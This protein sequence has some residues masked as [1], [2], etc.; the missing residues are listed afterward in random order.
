MAPQE[1]KHSILN[2]NAVNFGAHAEDATGLSYYLKGMSGAFNAFY[3]TLPVHEKIREYAGA[4]SRDIRFFPL[5]LSEKE[6]AKLMD[7]L[8]TWQEKPFPYKFFTYNC[9]HGI[10]ALLAASLDSLP[11][12]PNIMS[13]QDLALMLQNAN[14][15]GKPYVLPSLKERVLN[16]NNKEVAKLEFLE[17]KNMQKDAKRDTSRQRELAEL[18]HSVSK[19]EKEKR[20]LLKLENQKLKVHGYS[21]FDIGTQFIEREANAHIRFR[22]FLHDISD[23]SGYYSAQSTLEL[24]SLGLNA[25]NSGVNLQELSI[26]HIRSAPV[27]DPLFKSWSWDFLMG[28]KNDYAALNFGFGKSFYVHKQKQIAAEILLMNSARSK[29]DFDFDNFAGFEMQLNKRRAGNFRYGASFE[30][31][32]SVIDFEREDVHFK[33]WFAYDVNKSFNLYAEN[34]FGIKKQ[35]LLGLYLRFYL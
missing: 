10:Y 9:A 30:Y 32:R 27:H 28:Y 23:N 11:P 17:W 14:R 18:R 31:L 5:K 1:P 35:E 25:N 12:L 33:T 19:S 20:E 26:I 16:A 24:L 22:P 2:W 6:Y 29:T 8:R 15:L 21:R 7:T 34:I 4:E 3:D 13:P